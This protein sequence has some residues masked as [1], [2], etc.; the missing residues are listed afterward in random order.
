MSTSIEALRVYAAIG[1]DL[2]EVKRGVADA[3]AE[4]SKVGAG[5]ST[6]GL[7]EFVGKISAKLHSVGSA[8]TG[9][10]IG[11][12]AAFTAPVALAIKAASDLSETVNKADVVFGAAS[13]SVQQF[14]QGSAQAMGLSRQKAIEAAAS[15]GNLFVTIGSSSD[16]AAKMSVAMVR[17]ATDLASFHNIKPEEAIAKLQAG[18]VGQVR[19]L[20]EV[21][22]LLS[23]TATKAEATK[24][25]FKGVGGELTEQ[26]K[27]LAR[28]NLILAQSGTAQG[29]FA[30]TAE[31][32]ANSSRIV[33]AQLEDLGANLGSVLLPIAQ[34]ALHAFSD[35][36]E[37]FQQ[38][39]E[40]LQQTIVVIAG[41]GAV[42][43]P[44]V[45][46]AGQ[47]ISGIGAIGTAISA[48]SGLFDVF[49]GGAAAAGAAAGGAEV[50]VAG[51]GASFAAIAAPIAIAVAAIIAVAAAIASN[52]GG[53]RDKIGALISEIR[54]AFSSFIDFLY[55]MKDSFQQIWDGVLSIL[56]GVIAAIGD[57]LGRLVDV[58]RAILAAIQGD[59]SKAGE[60]L[61]SAS[62]SIWQ[63]IVSLV[64]GVVSGLVN[65]LSGLWGVI[66]TT[67][68][69]AW[70]LLK[71]SLASLAQIIVENVVAFFSSLPERIGAF[72]QAIPT[73]AGQALGLLAGETYKYITEF[74]TSVTDGLSSLGSLIWG[75]LK[76][77]LDTVVN[78]F[79]NLFATGR[80]GASSFLEGIWE[81]LKNLPQ[82]FVDA[83]Q[84]VFNFLAELPAK[85]LGW[86]KSIAGSFWS[87]L[88]SGFAAG[89]SGAL[90][91]S[92]TGVVTSLGDSAKQ[93]ISSVGSGLKSAMGGMLGGVGDAGKSEGNKAGIAVGEGLGQG[94]KNGHKQV[95]EGF[96]DL[97]KHA[98]EDLQSFIQ[99]LGFGIKLSTQLWNG[100]TGDLK[101]SLKDQSKAWADAQRDQDKALLSFTGRT[102]V[103]LD[104][105]N[106]F[107]KASGVDAKL[108]SKQF[109]DAFGASA[110]S[111]VPFI[112]KVKDA[113]KEAELLRAKLI[114]EFAQSLPTVDPAQLFGSASQNDGRGHG[115]EC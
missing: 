25:G 70:N 80:S 48:V 97:T 63:G 57:I 31:G 27:V 94:I 38:L 82:L 17:L 45:I 49:G 2:S 30:R 41:V 109:A 104:D 13:G 69:A 22:I 32:L 5:A 50:A 115:Q 40:G 6:A 8:I 107:I 18:L 62:E 114:V 19:P 1:V 101:A 68:V 103:S 11:M 10:G 111:L 98:Q 59:W 74:V 89:Q 23:E 47:I 91:K 105:I 9:I 78:F 100:M 14:A 81:F 34:K 77:A 12:T 71:D 37:K 67:A 86:G 106:N 76:S 16:E 24:L 35:L 44:L 21:G 112:N 72:L 58:I 96:D 87:G 65:I 79:V 36:L 83:V 66:S 85:L 108:S 46:I 4:L 53:V 20:R 3:D 43:G 99:T 110:E 54:A 61:K 33:K 56:G 42:L 39:P 28:Y 92:L 84:A 113:Q 73:I 64:V 93:N 90:E 52:V 55:S 75:A 95:K 51:L 102:K 60:L 88:Q 7:D 26:Q 29:D 15:F